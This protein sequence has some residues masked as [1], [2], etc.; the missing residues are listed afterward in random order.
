MTETA[1]LR[2]CLREGTRYLRPWMIIKIKTGL[3]I[4]ELFHQLVSGVSLGVPNMLPLNIDEYATPIC[5]S[6]AQGMEQPFLTCGIN[7]TVGEIIQFGKCIRFDVHITIEKP[8]VTS[9][10]FERIMIARNELRLPTPKQRDILTK[11]EVLF[12]EF[13]CLL[14]SNGLGWHF[15]QESTLGVKFLDSMT[16]VF[17]YLDPHWEKLAERY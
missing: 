10:A 13:H 7:M 1:V 16:E 8:S 2:A 14:K 4:G 15:G 9:N 11:K 12:N 6:V 5:V 3:M 17:W